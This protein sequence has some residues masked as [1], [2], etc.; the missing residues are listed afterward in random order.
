M[1]F[2]F[3]VLVP[4]LNMVCLEEGSFKQILAIKG[5]DF[6]KGQA[7][8]TIAGSKYPHLVQN[9]YPCLL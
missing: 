3:R 9:F 8:N 5:L 7:G 2:H 4:S 1:G 6:A